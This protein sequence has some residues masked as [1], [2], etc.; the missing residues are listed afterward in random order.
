MF[1]ACRSSVVF[2]SSSRGGIH[3]QTSHVAEGGGFTLI[4]LLV[5]IAIIAI[6]IGLLLPA[7]QKVREA[8]ARI[9]DANNLKQLSLAL[10]SCNDANGKMPA[11]Q[12]NFPTT[13]GGGWGGS[14]TNPAGRGTIFYYLLPYIEQGTMYNG[15]YDVSNNA[16]FSVSPT[17]GWS[18]NPGPVVV[19]S[20]ISPG[21]P[22]A[23]ASGLQNTQNNQQGAI[24]YGSNQFVFGGYGWNG[25]NGGYARC[26]PSRTASPTP[27]S[28]RNS[29]MSAR[30]TSVTGAP[31]TTTAPIP[32]STRALRTAVIAPETY[33]VPQ[34]IGSLGVP[35]Q[36]P[37]TSQCNY[38]Q[39]QAPDAGGTMVGLGDGSVRLVNSGVTRTPGPRALFPADGTPLGS[40]W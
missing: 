16:W 37:N 31:R 26:A 12:G 32:T 4:E 11:D 38:N 40:D 8:A 20:F 14:G 36:Q 35:Q 18:G 28:S 33:G 13:N 24:S 25:A 15:T 30:G 29:T 5:V 17:G 6:L 27:S 2:F 3:G 1:R 7:V 39:V 19:K 34:N 22:T 10:H 21:D 23:P 9:S